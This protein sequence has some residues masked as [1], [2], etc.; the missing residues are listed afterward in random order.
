MNDMTLELMKYAGS[1]FC[2]AQIPVLFALD[3]LGE[4]NPALVR[5][6]A[7]LCTGLG[8]RGGSCGALTGG[9]CLLGFYAGRGS[10]EEEEDGRLQAMTDELHRW[11]IEETTGR[12]GGSLCE[13]IT[14]GAGP[15][16]Q[17]CGT[18]V[19]EITSR[20]LELLTENGIDPSESP[21]SSNI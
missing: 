13:D 5:S 6:L 16:L 1:G 14:G 21:F 17:T 3:L 12:F 9:A 10:A 18:L 15:D 11:F 7:G 2:C 4:R 19:A 20:C 8:A